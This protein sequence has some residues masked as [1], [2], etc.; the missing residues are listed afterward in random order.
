MMPRMS[1][2]IMK[3]AMATSLLHQLE[4]ERVIAA[5][6][7]HEGRKTAAADE[8]GM[9]RRSTSWRKLRHHHLF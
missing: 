1:R 3:H 7:K 2:N 8:L 6:C 4:R 9:S 5:L